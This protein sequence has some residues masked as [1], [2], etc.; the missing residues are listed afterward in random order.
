MESRAFSTYMWP[1]LTCFE[2]FNQNGTFTVERG[3]DGISF[4]EKGR[5]VTEQFFEKIGFKWNLGHF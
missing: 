4:A 2:Q 5:K 1:I 3:H